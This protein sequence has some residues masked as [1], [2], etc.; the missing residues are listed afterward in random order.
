MNIDELLEHVG[1][2]LDE[3]SIEH[4]RVT[5]T[6]LDRPSPPPVRRSFVLV[7]MAGVA[8]LIIGVL[9]IA[10]RRDGDPTP[11]DQPNGTDVSTT[12]VAPTTVPGVPTQPTGPLFGT[13]VP[14]DLAPLV[15][16]DAPDWTLTYIY[17][18]DDLPLGDIDPH[19]LVLVGSGPRYDA[20]TFE[21]WTTPPVSGE[22]TGGTPVK[23]AGVDGQ[24][25]VQPVDTE[26]QQAG[27]IILLWWPL[28]DGRVAHASSLRIDEDQA[29][30]LAGAVSFD[31]PTPTIADPGGLTVV[32]SA[33]PSQWLSFEYQYTNGPKGAQI[34]G[35]NLGVTALLGYGIGSEL[36][37]TRTVDGIE[38]AYKVTADQYSALWQA[39][40]WAFSATATG[41]GSEG[42][43]LAMLSS[44]R[45]SDRTTFAAAGSALKPLMPGD[46]LDVV[47]Q[48]EVG[49]QLPVNTPTVEWAPSNVA[50]TER[51]FA[52]RLFLGVGCGWS[53]TWTRAY[54][55]SDQSSMDAAAT[56]VDTVVAKIEQIGDFAST[57]SDLAAS[58]RAGH[59]DEV[60]GF[61]SNDCPTWSANIG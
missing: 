60:A 13:E 32:D 33:A 15:L 26:T 45:L 40:A 46:H 1:E 38:V 22:I 6:G 20:Q 34:N 29:I 48:L 24:M 16:I 21:A 25:M 35:S 14:A 41:L 31:T 49:V 18:T 5:A 12:L 53:R 56:G 57:W 51:D 19:Q 3:L 52:F 10:S 42:E 17:G 54:D 47:Q 61:G 36:R 37:T 30:A 58:M 9:V 11:Q 2:R 27:P 50:T 43:F 4:T 28:A 39:G 59:R 44:M 55:A 8:V 7:A 23:V